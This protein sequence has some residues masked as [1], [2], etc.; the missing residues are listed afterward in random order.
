MKIWWARLVATGMTAWSAKDK[1]EHL[2]ARGISNDQN[3]RRI[4]KK[5]KKLHP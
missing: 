4:Y 3:T 2:A 5:Y 1:A